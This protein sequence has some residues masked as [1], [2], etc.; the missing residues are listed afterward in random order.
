ML[1]SRHQLG[2]YNFNFTSVNKERFINQLINKVCNLINF[3]F[4]IFKVKD[5]NSYAQKSRAKDLIK[6][7]KG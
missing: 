6:V 4:L 5:K 7:Q 1:Q 2:N 3:C